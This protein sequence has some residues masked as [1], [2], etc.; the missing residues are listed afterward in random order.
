MA[1]QKVFALCGIV[2]ILHNGVP[3]E[4]RMQ[5]LEAAAQE[6]LEVRHAGLFIWQGEH[7]ADGGLRM[8]HGPSAEHIGHMLIAVGT[9]G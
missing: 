3:R 8:L 7:P 1:A 9:G 4:L 6:T 2:H 5:A